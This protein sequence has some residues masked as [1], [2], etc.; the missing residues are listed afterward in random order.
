MATTKEKMQTV[1]SDSNSTW[2]WVDSLSKNVDSLS[3][4]ADKIMGTVDKVGSVIS[5]LFGG[6]VESATVETSVNWVDY[7]PLVV[8]GGLIAMIF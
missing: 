3:I 1:K 4:N 2:A 6:K 5:S 8:A 7:L